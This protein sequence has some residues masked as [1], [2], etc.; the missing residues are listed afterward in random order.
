MVSTS[1]F[2][3]LEL[4]QRE[5]GAPTAALSSKSEQQTVDAVL[6]PAFRHFRGLGVDPKTDTLRKLIKSS[7]L[8][9]ERKLNPVYKDLSESER[10]AKIRD[11]ALA[12][13]LDSQRVEN[14]TILIC[15]H[16]QRDSRCGVLG[17][18]LHAE[19]TWYINE[20]KPID[21]K[22][23]LEARPG[24]F[25]A[26][27]SSR[28]STGEE[29]SPASSSSSSSTSTSCDESIN[30]NVGMISHIGGHKWA[31][32]VIMYIPP[33]F[34][35]PLSASKSPHPLAGMGIWYG[36]VEPRHVEGIVEQTLLQGKVIQDLFRGGLSQ[37]G[38]TLRL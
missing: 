21:G 17:P 20:R 35:L 30:V 8:P 10:Q 2:T 6:F 11:P 9:E 5:S 28:L 37:D 3:P 14:P 1:S 27:S 26:S 38:D 24:A 33:T 34:Q 29:S 7:L 4:A 23:K 15:S 25:L 18:L 22:S 31:G 32:N 12:A 36:R 13:S 16:G 19:F